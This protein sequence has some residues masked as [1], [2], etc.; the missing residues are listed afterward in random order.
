MGQYYKAISIDADEC[1]EPWDYEEGAKLMEHSYI[2]NNTVNA[3]ESLISKNGNWHNTRIV[4]AGDYADNEINS[5]HNLYSLTDN[6][7]NPATNSKFGFRYIVNSTKMQFID[8][9]KIKKDA[10]GYRIH[11]LPLL[12]AEG[13][14]RGGGDFRKDDNRI[15]SWAR[16]KIFATN[17]KPKGYEEIDGQFE[18]K[19]RPLKES[20]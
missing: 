3:V 14:G 2:G 8:K 7:V 1:I 5:E 13:N 15:G 20:H 11:P 18:E 16:D 19:L 12:T 17:T 10:D 9:K 6:K 4:W